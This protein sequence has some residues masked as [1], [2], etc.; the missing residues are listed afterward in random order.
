MGLLILHEHLEIRFLIEIWVVFAK[1]IL[2]S[3]YKVKIDNNEL[4]KQ[5]AWES[6]VWLTSEVKE[7][8]RFRL[9]MMLQID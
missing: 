9:N 2:S 1:I 8:I 3:K 6:R 4:F 7:D 5:V